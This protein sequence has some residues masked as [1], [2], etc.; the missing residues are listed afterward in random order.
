VTC[1]CQLEKWNTSLFSED[2]GRLFGCKIPKHVIDQ[3][4]STKIVSRPLRLT[5]ATPCNTFGINSPQICERSAK[6]PQA[7]RKRTS[8]YPTKNRR[9]AWFQLSPPFSSS[10]FGIA[11][12]SRL[13]QHYIRVVVCKLIIYY[14]HFIVITKVFDKQLRIKS[15][16]IKDWRFNS[17]MPSFSNSNK[18]RHVSSLYSECTCKGLSAYD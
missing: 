2:S 15:S 9:T 7:N 16:D 3:R 4:F 18:I 5:S 11:W 14:S 10:F 1:F 17:S 6:I 13:T 12:R 8:T